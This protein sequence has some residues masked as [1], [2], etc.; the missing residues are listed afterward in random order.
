MEHRR[1]LIVMAAAV[2]GSLLL[3]ACADKAAEEQ[4]SSGAAT[5]HEIDGSEVSRVTLTKDAA[6]RLDIQT[7]T[8]SPARPGPGTQI[9]YAAVLYD[10]KGDTWAFV[11][12]KALTYVRESIKVDRI[13]G[14][15]AFLKDGP[16]AGTNVVKVGASELYGSEIG[17]GDE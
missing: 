4:G 1:R 6:R 3:G 5:V 10:P 11:N 7:E 12:R 2:I 8:V 13:E 17:V 9:P 15:V 16:S 14:D